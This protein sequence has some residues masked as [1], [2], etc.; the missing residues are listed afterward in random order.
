MRILLDTHILLWWMFD[1]R[2]LPQTLRDKISDG[3]NSVYFSSI[4]IGEIAIKISLD[5]LFAPREMLQLLN[6][7]GFVE[8]PLTA[9]HSEELILL[10]WLHRDP[11]DR[12]LIA[13]AKVER[14]ML[15]TLDLKSAEYDVERVNA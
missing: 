10:P 13:Q 5:Q 14:L 1:D 2:R 11:F 6:E 3:S 12:L 4:S 8:L 7:A 15:A 9:R